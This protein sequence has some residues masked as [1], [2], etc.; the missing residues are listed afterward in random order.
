MSIQQT[1]KAALDAANTSAGTRIYPVRAP[2]SP[3][4]PFV[5]YAVVAN[6]PENVLSGPPPIDSTRLQIDVYDRTYAGMQTLSDAVRA[7]MQS[8][9]AGSILELEIDN[10]EPDTRLY[11]RVLDYTI[12]V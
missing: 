2:D 5:V 11:R 9:V 3:T 4:L 10:Y 7:A 8:A 1:V 12:W 6:A